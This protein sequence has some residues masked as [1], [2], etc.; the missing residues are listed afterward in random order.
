MEENIKPIA[1][2]LPQFHAIKE[3]D[4]WWGEGFTEW[5]N[6]KKAK[7]LFEGHY[8]PHEP[9][10]DNYYDLSTVDEMIAQAQLAREHGI[11]GFCFY[12]YWFNGK[13]LLEKPLHNLLNSPE[14]D[15]PFCLSWANENWTRTW[16]GRDKQVLMKQEYNLEDDRAHIRYR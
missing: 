12:H 3:N 10:N 16:D 1:L 6:V 5:T 9:L 13:L 8:Q 4:A 2:Y 15:F 7:P 11:Y 14:P